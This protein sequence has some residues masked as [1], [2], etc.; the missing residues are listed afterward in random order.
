MN[1]N[2]YLGVIFGQALGDA[3]GKYTE[4]RYATMIR[5]DFPTPAD[6]DFPPASGAYRDTRH[7]PCHWT[8]DTEHMMLLMDMLIT[9]NNTI[10]QCVFARSL[11]H[12]VSHGNEELGDTHGFGCGSLTGKLC[13]DDRFVTEPEYVARKAWNG[14]LAPNGSLMRTSIMGC[15]NLER[16]AAVH[17]AVRMGRA[18]HYDPRCAYAI[19]IV[20]SIISEL[21][22][23]ADSSVADAE[24]DGIMERAFAW[25]DDTTIGGESH[26]VTMLDGSKRDAVSIVREFVNPALSLQDLCLEE[27][28][29]YVLKCMAVAL[30]ALRNRHRGW[31]PVILDIVLAGGDA[32][33]NAAVAGAVLGAYWGFDNLPHEWLERMPHWKYLMRKAE[34]LLDI[35]RSTAKSIG[36]P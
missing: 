7:T 23:C 25:L 27:Q 24:M 28:Q 29:G 34:R 26:A 20:T 14:M 3:M 13:M 10:D 11:A 36:T 31:N 6:F 1:N 17:D 30:W 22:A 5:Q 19:A 12:W 8:D 21:V 15:R 2:K 4:F 33:T 18:S 9:C 16:T 32:D 35:V